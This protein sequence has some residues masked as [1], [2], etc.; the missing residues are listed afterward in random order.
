MANYAEAL[1]SNAKMRKNPK[2]QLES[3]HLSK[4]TNGGVI[5]RHR[6][7]TFEGKEPEHAFGAEDGHEL[8]AHIEKHL[9]IKMPAA[10]VK[11]S[12]THGAQSQEP[13]PEADED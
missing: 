11:E 2:P 12:E 3:I 9:G 8:A 4:A 1:D 5:A 6:M 13:E 7:T 10:K